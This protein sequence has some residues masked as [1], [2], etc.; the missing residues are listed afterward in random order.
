MNVI[1]H[2]DE[3][4]LKGN[5]QGTFT[6]KLAD[7]IR[8]LFKGVTA[9]RV[10]GG[11]VLEGLKENEWDRL[12]N[13]PGIAK[14]AAAK[15]CKRD[16]DSI[17]KILSGWPIDPTAK[18]FRISASRADKSYKLTSE[19]INRELGRFIGETRGL[20]VNLHDFD[21]NLHVDIGR[22]KAIIYEKMSEGAG[23]LPVGTAGRVLCLLS[24]GIDSPVAAYK[25]M[26]RGA[27]VELIHFQ[28]QTQV[29]EEVS[30]KII[31][32][33]KVLARYQPRI[34]L[35][36]VPFGDWQK[37]IIMKIPADYRMLASRRLMFK[38]SAKTAV[39][40][41]CQALVVGDSLGQVASQTLEN[42]SVVYEAVTMLK[43]APLIG[44]NKSEIVKLAR[45]IGTLD[46][47]SRPYE[48]CCSLFV[49]K[50]PKTKAKIGEVLK[51]EKTLDLSA[52]DNVRGIS[53]YISI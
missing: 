31:D 50:H 51:L 33:A 48:D 11:F 20:K 34:K 49:A 5:N 40:D 21:L 44:A 2:F 35:T 46:I 37:Q 28:N 47:S 26:L 19:E 10:E 6:K 7:N 24:G 13:I 36:I 8:R 16:L 52:L 15:E 3:I 53:Y 12:A 9:R 45:R 41:G 4:F 22:T 32:L 42:M 43:F 17:K 23:G 27:E 29:T 38:I 30:E 25:M 18:T 1:V 39:G 14:Y